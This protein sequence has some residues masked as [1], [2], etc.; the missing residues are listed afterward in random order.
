MQSYGPPVAHDV[1]CW[2]LKMRSTNETVEVVPPGAVLCV[3]CHRVPAD[4][5]EPEWDEDGF[6]IVRDPHHKGSA[7]AHHPLCRSLAS[8]YMGGARWNHRR[9]TKLP[10]SVPVCKLCNGKPPKP[11]HQR[12]NGDLRTTGRKPSGE[13]YLQRRDGKKPVMVP[14]R[15]PACSGKALDRFEEGRSWFC[16]SCTWEGAVR[17]PEWKLVSK[18]ASTENG[19]GR[20]TIRRGPE[21][22][23]EHVHRLG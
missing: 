7:I 2:L 15:C 19:D 4:V 9:V 10:D 6:I 20:A 21:K 18:P 16:F 22:L 8:K 5:R 17:T 1:G 14:V 13:Y 11:R 23:V 12:P 3:H